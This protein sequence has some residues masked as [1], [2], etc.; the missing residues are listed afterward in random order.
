MYIIMYK[1]INGMLFLFYPLNKIFVF[2]VLLFKYDFRI[3]LK[4]DIRHN[5]LL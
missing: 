2:I 1:R 4:G 3:A 5:K